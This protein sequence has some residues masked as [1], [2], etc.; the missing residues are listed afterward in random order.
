MATKEKNTKLELVTEAD[1][2]HYVSLFHN[3]LENVP[4]KLMTQKVCDIA[5]RLNPYDRTYLYI[6][7]KFRT[8]KMFFVACPDYGAETK[9]FAEGQIQAEWGISV[10]AFVALKKKGTLPN[11]K[12]VTDPAIIE[13]C[14]KKAFSENP[15][16]IASM[17]KDLIPKIVNTP[18]D[19]N[20]IIRHQILQVIVTKLTGQDGN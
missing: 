13:L 1:A 9:D 2:A 11:L 16:V 20:K 14:Y 6:P 17:P 7:E 5:F 8:F 10:S 18:M 4:V 19:V 12:K 3:K 15:D